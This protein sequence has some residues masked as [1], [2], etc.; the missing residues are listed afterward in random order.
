MALTLG[1]GLIFLGFYT[2][3]CFGYR[4]LHLALRPPSSFL[5]AN[6]LPTVPPSGAVWY[7]IR[8]GI[9]TASPSHR[10]ASRGSYSVPPPFHSLL[11][12]AGPPDPSHRLRSD[13]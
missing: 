9:V 10:D 13:R 8:R 1:T 6:M 11:N 5:F 7:L 3:S 12:D 2:V 4:P